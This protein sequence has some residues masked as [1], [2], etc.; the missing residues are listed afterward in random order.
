MTSDTKWTVGP[1]R[2]VTFPLNA[3]VMTTFIRAPYV[4]PKKEM[5]IRDGV[6]AAILGVPL[7]CGGICSGTPLAPMKL[8]ELSSITVGAYLMDFDLDLFDAYHFADCGNVPIIPGNHEKSVELVE[9]A[10]SEIIQAGALPFLVG[11]DDTVPIPG[12]RALSKSTKGKIG[13]LKFDTHFDCS[14]EIGGV[15]DMSGTNL[16]RAIELPNCNPENV[17]L[18][19]MHGGDNPK[20]WVEWV[21]DHNLA[22]FKMRDIVNRGITN[23]MRD[24]LERVWDGTESVYVNWDIDVCCS[25][26]G[27]SGRETIEA[28]EMIGGTKIGCMDIV[29]S[30][31]SAEACELSRYMIF[32]VLGGRKIHLE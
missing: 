27:L 8:R 15:K 21:K 32:S 3:S 19:G 9:E 31:G 24:A 1:E 10:A 5:L 30:N 18:V 29:E 20:E 6:K 4:P 14:D 13:F 25:P 23:V 26:Y 2:Q 17:A 22:L 7:E 28:C 11:G 12:S 16:C